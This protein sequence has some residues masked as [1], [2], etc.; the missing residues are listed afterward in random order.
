MRKKIFLALFTFTIAF[1]AFA[2]PAEPVTDKT[3]TAAV[4]EPVTD[5]TV[6]E[7]SDAVVEPVVDT[8]EPVVIATEPPDAAAEPVI[9]IT[10]PVEIANESVESNL[11]QFPPNPRESWKNRLILYIPNRIVDFL[12]IADASLGIGPVVKMKVWATRYMA[13]GAGIGTSAKIIKGY[14]RQYGLG[15]ESG[16]NISFAMFSADDTKMYETTRGVQKYFIYDFGIPSIDDKVYNFWRGPRD[17]FS[18]GVELAL[19]VDGKAELHPFEIVDFLA[20][21]FFLDPKGDDFTMK[22][23]KN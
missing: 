12:D 6:A 18:I 23:I 5:I 11:E 16:E 4:T 9:D 2:A 17:I 14:N 3:G 22:D 21:I 19:G 8:A 1:V 7:P 13:F 20:G 10:E 15:L